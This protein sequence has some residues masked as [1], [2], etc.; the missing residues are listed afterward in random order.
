MKRS[1]AV[2]EEFCRAD[3]TG[4]S[5]QHHGGGYQAAVIVYATFW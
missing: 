1:K 5:D 4:R 2:A 3:R